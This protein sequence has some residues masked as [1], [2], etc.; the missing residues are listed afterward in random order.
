[1]LSWIY[2]LCCTKTINY[3]GFKKYLGKFHSEFP[4]AS[5]IN[6]CPRTTI[7][8]YCEEI[9]VS[10]DTLYAGGNDEKQEDFGF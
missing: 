9:N 10:G 7:Y 4:Q 2:K 1:M 5:D 8:N 6:N 3:L